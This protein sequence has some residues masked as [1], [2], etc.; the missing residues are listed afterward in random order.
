MDTQG[1]TVLHHS[2]SL[3]SKSTKAQR[4]SWALG[5]D[6]VIKPTVVIYESYPV[7]Q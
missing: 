2:S 5:I 3:K 7:R 4:D 1:S 6:L